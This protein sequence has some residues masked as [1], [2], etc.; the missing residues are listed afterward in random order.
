MSCACCEKIVLSES[1]L[2]IDHC[3]ET[4]AVRGLLCHSCN[5]GIGG[6]GDNL[7]GL[8]K[9]AYYLLRASSQENVFD[10]VSKNA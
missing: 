9:A 5:V 4:G 8:K 2:K 10:E 3:H 1:D 6:L 7:D